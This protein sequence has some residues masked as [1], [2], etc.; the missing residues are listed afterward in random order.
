MSN[1][2]LTCEMKLCGL[3]L[4]KWENYLIEILRKLEK[5][6]KLLDITNRAYDRIDGNDVYQ[7]VEEKTTNFLYFIVKNHVFIDG[8]KRIGACLFIFFLSFYDILYKDNSSIIGS[9]LLT[10][11]TLLNAQLNPKE[12][13][14]LIS[15]TMNFLT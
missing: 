15:L 8:N 14:I 9:M 7:S 4:I 1:W 10:T 6:V 2:K 3:M 13:D 12:K 5:M 11:L